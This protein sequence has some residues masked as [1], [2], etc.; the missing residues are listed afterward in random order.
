M[1][2]QADWI[3]CYTEFADKLLAYKNNRTELLHI[4]TNVYDELNLRNP[5]MENGQVLEDI[6]PFTVFGAFNK[7]ITDE[8]RINLIK[9]IGSKLGVKAKIPTD[10]IG[11][12]LLNNLKAWFFRYKEERRPEDIPNLWD[13]FEKALCYA[14]EPTE[15]NRMAFIKGYNTVREQGC[16]KWNITMGL[17]WIRPLTYLNLDGNNRSFLLSNHFP[18]P[19]QVMK[20][21]KLKQVPKAE[22]YLALVDLCREAF[23][24]EE[25]AF[26][27]FPT[28]S[29]LAWKTPGE[30]VQKTNAEFSKWFKPL[31][32][33]LKKLGGAAKPDEAC[34]QIAED[35][36]LGEDVLSEV[37][38]KRGTNKFRNEVAWARQYLVYS[39]IIDNGDR[40][41]WRLTDKGYKV[42]FSEEII[43]EILR[44]GR[45]MGQ[46]NNMPEDR[47][48]VADKEDDYSTANQYEVYTEEEFLDEVFM[49][50]AT[51]TVLINLLKN[52]KNIILQGAPGVGKTF[53]AKRLAYAMMGMKDTSRVMMI[54][55]HQ[56]YSYEDFI[57]GYRPTNNGFELA[58]GP[59]YEFCKRA[60]QDKENEYFFIIDE[61]NR[62]NLSKIF[63]ELLM[64]IEK[65]KRGEAIRLIYSEEPFT[66]PKNVYII[67]MM[68]TAD[69]SLAMID[70]ALRRRFAFFE[71]EPAFDLEGFE[72]VISLAD[73]VK[74][75]KLVAEVKRL[76]DVISKDEALGNGFRIGHSYLCT[77][78][79]VTDEW[80][81]AVIEYE[82]IPLIN[83]YWFDEP[84]KVAEWSRKLRGVL[85][86]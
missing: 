3:I 32:K 82:L 37:R 13:F 60:S 5:F 20:F 76:N 44:E 58:A 64:L 63:G 42:D 24:K 50:T 67:G 30:K 12:P 59:F 86:D 27:D 57:M 43:M 56:S 7:G 49:S 41:I 38:G 17:Y 46:K 78:D 23:N 75:N 33:A 71:M 48:L 40:G 35:E 6:C 15:G 85:N 2:T 11:I 31:V 69:R 80:L 34:K 65:D 72:Q 22:E 84:D 52:K 16:I 61:I 36:A 25:V 19:D 47:D 26:H 81:Q 18:F 74:F 8:N 45:K 10:F 28:L 77:K 1:N 51:C 14:D 73:N 55:F 62:G 54:Q 9:G 83:E 39:D 29:V 21:S 66:V 4:L 53:A 70:Y 79:V 68:N